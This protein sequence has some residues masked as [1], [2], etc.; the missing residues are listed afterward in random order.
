MNIYQIR[1]RQ[2][3]E[4]LIAQIR[5]YDLKQ[6]LALGTR[7]LFRVV[8]RIRL[9]E[10]ADQHILGA[11][12]PNILLLALAKGSRSG[13]WNID[14]AGFLVLCKCLWDLQQTLQDNDSLEEEGE[15]I[16][17]ALSE[18]KPDDPRE[19]IPAYALPFAREN[20][21]LLLLARGITAQNWGR[22]ISW[23]DWAFDVMVLDQLAKN[24]PEL[25]KKLMT[26]FRV[27]NAGMLY[28]TGLLLWTL[29]ANQGGFL[30]L[31]SV[32]E[33]DGNV[34][35]VPSQAC[36]RI[37]QLM[38]FQESS[39]L[40]EWLTPLLD[41]RNAGY[42]AFH[43][44]LMRSKP[45]VHLDITESG[46]YALLAP[47]DYMRSFRHAVFSALYKLGSKGAV[48]DII[49]A[50]IE[51]SIITCFRSLLGKRVDDYSKVPEGADVVINFEN[52]DLIVEIK[53]NVS[54]MTV[55]ARLAPLDIPQIW[56]RLFKAAQQCAKTIAKRNNSRKNI[57]VI[58][59][60]DNIV[61]ECMPFTSFAEESGIKAKLGI[62]QIEVVSWK[63][64]QDL[65]TH[66]TPD[67][68]ARGVEAK[69]TSQ[70]PLSQGPLVANRLKPTITTK[71]YGHLKSFKTEM[72]GVLESARA[73][74]W[75]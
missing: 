64:F 44:P 1:I 41:D 48:G 31:A 65:L 74:R 6:L 70:N 60:A 19:M 32:T 67:A 54:S 49:G 38:S 12:G 15:K 28:R 20:S 34:V 18:Y 11:Y 42:E 7:E 72:F 36:D 27:E 22:G 33:T 25:H 35:N 17:R 46:S 13:R 57:A 50:S 37:L 58:V 61:G 10:D 71:D 14:R 21:W 43:A 59:V 47:V 51:A 3:F 4:K 26:H 55:A 8:S 40:P 62:D 5:L 69:W 39:V 2:E 63:Q 75:L 29:S 30:R 24:S 66:M 53:S 9:Q 52:F 23:N 68:F 16:V 45:Y 56:G 73:R